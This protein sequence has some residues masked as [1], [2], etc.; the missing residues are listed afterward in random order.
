MVFYYYDKNQLY[1][2]LN[3]SQVAYFNYSGFFAFAFAVL[4]FNFCCFAAVVSFFLHFYFKT[5]NY[6]RVSKD[7]Q[8]Q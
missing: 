7:T 5:I 6:L 4:L 2:Q 3:V 8:Q 1:T